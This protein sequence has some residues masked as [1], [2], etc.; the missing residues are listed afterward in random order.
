M[1]DTNIIPQLYAKGSFVANAPFDSVVSPAAFYTV[2]DTVT[3]SQMQARKAD[4]F[5][6]VWEPA[7]VS[8][9]DYQ[10][11][12]N[13]LINLNGAIVVLSSKNGPDVY[14]PSTYIKSF[15]LVDGVIYEHLCIITDC[16]AVP[17][18]FK[19]VLNSAVDHFNNYMKD[20]CGL[21]NPRTV[22]GTIQTRGYVPKEQAEAWENTRQSKIKENPSDLVRL[23]N[24]LATNAQL[25][26]YVA[27]LE[28][29]LKAVQTTSTEDKK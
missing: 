7:G 18:D 21:E 25:T 12:L 1:T 28:A 27:E 14:V 19:D 22:I 5:K 29:A 24:A 11:Q 13:T 2:V 15:P 4:L 26:A 10:V 9:A 17:P 3:P 6:L 16:G 8:D 23:N 20:N